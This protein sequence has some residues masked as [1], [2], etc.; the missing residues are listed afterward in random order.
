MLSLLKNSI[1]I[2]V[3][4]KNHNRDAHMTRIRAV[5]ISWKPTSIVQCA[6][7]S[8]NIPPTLHCHI[9][10]TYKQENSSRA[11]PARLG[12]NILDGGSARLGS[13]ILDGGSAR[14]EFSNP[15]AHM[16]RAA[17]RISARLTA[18]TNPAAPLSQD[19]SRIS[20][21]MHHTL[22]ILGCVL[23][24]PLQRGISRSVIQKQ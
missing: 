10:I 20:G 2:D 6:Q 24:F 22:Q 4:K 5:C 16:S 1:V 19:G 15:A 11:E 3:M 13:N 23:Y 14:L 9:L 21:N 7:P 8:S 12:S 17:A 18:F